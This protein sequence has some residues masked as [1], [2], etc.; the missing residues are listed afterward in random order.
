MKATT[1]PVFCGIAL[2]AMSAAGASHW[3]SV[4]QIVAA[5]Q[6]DA[7]PAPRAPLPVSTPKPDAQPRPQTVASRKQNTKTHA[8][9]GTTAAAD[10]GRKEFYEALVARMEHLQSQN[11]DLLDQLAET[12]RDLMKL[13]FRVDT[14]S[15]SFRPL[16]VSEDRIDDTTIDDGPGVLPPRAEPVFLPTYE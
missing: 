7:T 2:I 8:S 13:E 1:M 9:P 14:H 12:N 15:E 3:W 4:Q 11:R 10:P 6:D 5:F 16:P